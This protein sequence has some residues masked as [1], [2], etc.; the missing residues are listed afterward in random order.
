MTAAAAPFPIDSGLLRRFLLAEKGIRW[1]IFEAPGS[2]RA[3][4]SPSGPLARVR[5]AHLHDETARI[6]ERADGPS[7]VVVVTSGPVGALFLIGEF[8]R[9]G[10]P[11]ELSARSGGELPGFPDGAIEAQWDPNA[12]GSHRVL[13]VADIVNLARYAL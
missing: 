12:R 6:E 7:G 11:T 8:M 5:L 9:R 4:S 13:P 1:R 10:L 3:A 2:R